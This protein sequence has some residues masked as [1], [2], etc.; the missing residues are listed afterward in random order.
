MNI[1]KNIIGTIV[2]ILTVFISSLSL[3]QETVTTKDGR[4]IVLK[5]DGTWQYS[6]SSSPKTYDLSTAIGVV[7][8]YLSASNW[9]DRIQYVLSESNVEEKMEKTYSSPFWKAPSFEIQASAESKDIAIGDCVIIKAL[10]ENQSQ[11]DFYVVKTENG[12]KIDWYAS[13]GVNNIT[14][15]AFEASKPTA[16]V[17]LRAYAQLTDY[18][19]FEFS[20]SGNEFWSIELEENDTRKTFGHGYINKNSIMGKQLYELLKDGNKHK[21]FVEVQFPNNASGDCFYITRLIKSDSWFIN[22]PDAEILEET[23]AAPIIK[24]KD[25][26]KSFSLPSKGMKNTDTYRPHKKIGQ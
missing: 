3:S 15:V 21:V 19:N 16:R 5:P 9:H 6:K 14:A 17:K 26:Q 1:G 13:K 11:S 20:D 8:A 22:K 18:Y 2:V 24:T 25:V 7:S 10:I 23:P 12:Y 4:T